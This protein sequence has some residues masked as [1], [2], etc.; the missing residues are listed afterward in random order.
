MKVTEFFLGIGPRVWS[1]RR[2]EVEYGI[3][4][5]PAVAYVRII[6]MSNMDEV[7][8][9]DEARTYRQKPYRQRMLVA[10]AGS[11]MHF[12]L[13]LILAFGLFA[14]AGQQDIHRWAVDSA[15]PGSAAAIAGLRHGDR[16]LAVAGH[17]VSTHDQLSEQV[18][19]RPDERIDL[20]VVRNGRHLDHPHDAG[21]TGADHR[22]GRRGRVA[23]APIRERSRSTRSTRPAS[24]TR[25]AFVTATSSVRSTA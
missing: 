6:G 4:A 3:K 2:G 10:V 23:A 9:E 5:I 18:V 1:F 11:G 22:N 24:S 15:S 12:A 19:Q 25:R 16:I 14:F 17:P 7:P 21:V 20:A 13:A 8:P